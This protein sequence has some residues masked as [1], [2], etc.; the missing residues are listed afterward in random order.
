MKKFLL[1]FGILAIA[2]PVFAGLDSKESVSPTFLRNYGLS[3]ETVQYVQ[4][5]KAAANGEKYVTPYSEMSYRKYYTNSD[6]WNNVVDKTR[7]FFNYLDPSLDK[8]KFNRQD[9]KFYADS[10]DML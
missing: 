2:S 8:G 5:Q 3:N 9:I 10:Q 1:V 7:S 6:V 4:M